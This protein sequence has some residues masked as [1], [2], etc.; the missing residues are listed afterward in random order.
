MRTCFVSQRKRVDKIKGG[1]IINIS[2]IV[3]AILIE[4]LGDV[5][6][7]GGTLGGAVGGGVSTGVAGAV[8]GA[9]GGATGGDIGAKFAARRLP[10]VSFQNNIVYQAS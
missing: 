3:N 9:S 5:G 8:G 1:T 10:M 7:R 6:A 2:G 4:E